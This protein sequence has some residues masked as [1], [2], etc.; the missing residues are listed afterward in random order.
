M[1][2]EVAIPAALLD[3]VH[4]TTTTTTPIAEAETATITTTLDRL[5]SNHLVLYQTLPYLP[6]SAVL[7]LAATSRAFRNLIYSS[8]VAFRY[9]D[10][11]RVKAARFD[12]DPIDTGGEL[13]HNTQ[14]DEHLTEDEFYS[15]PLRGIFS[16]LCRSNL[17]SSVH[18]LVLDGL[19]VTAELVHDIL[20]GPSFRIRILSLRDVKNLNERKLQQALTTACRPNRPEGA[21]YLKGIYLFTRRGAVSRSASS[22]PSSSPSSSGASVGLGSGSS[23][24]TS[25]GSLA[26][27]TSLQRTTLAACGAEGGDAWYDRRGKMLSRGLSREWANTLLACRGV[28]AFDTVLCAGPRHPNSRAFGQV[29]LTDFGEQHQPQWEV[30]THAVGGCAGCGDAPE[31]MTV[32]GDSD[33]PHDFPLLAPAP[34]HSS[35]VKEA[36]CPSG[37]LIEE[38]ELE[39]IFEPG[40]LWLAGEDDWGRERARAGVGWAWINNP[41]QRRFWSPHEP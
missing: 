37:V 6:P 31:G 10:L 7:N 18:T 32:W 28:I 16:N 19:S 1:A 35:S 25:A 30:A 3:D 2:Q 40:L 24:S 20:T 14:L 12:I 41:W 11:T 9:L 26:L 15:G 38:R 13:W 4:T 34:L 39:R 36:C 23:R 22:S 8:P 33:P 17:L 5:L 29:E 27:T 21:P